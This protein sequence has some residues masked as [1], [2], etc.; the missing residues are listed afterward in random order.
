MM[1]NCR[2]GEIWKFAM[3]FLG[4]RAAMIYFWALMSGGLIEDPQFT[5]TLTIDWSEKSIKRFNKVF[6][7]TDWILSYQCQRYQLVNKVHLHNQWNS[8][9]T[10]NLKLYESSRQE[11]NIEVANRQFACRHDKHRCFLNTDI[12]SSMSRFRVSLRDTHYLHK[13]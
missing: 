8:A 9:F 2:R 1:G 7:I 10:E 11:F 13:K 6:S 5:L 3:L 12:L 4:F